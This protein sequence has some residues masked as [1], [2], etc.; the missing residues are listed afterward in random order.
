MKPTPTPSM[1]VLSKPDFVLYIA[2]SFI[3]GVT[4]C[5]A[6]LPTLKPYL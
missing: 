5:L 1:V 3:A 6:L 2:S 4:L